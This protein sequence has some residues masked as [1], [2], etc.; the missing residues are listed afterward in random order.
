MGETESVAYEVS[1]GESDGESDA[2]RGRRTGLV[3][4]ACAGSA[5]SARERAA[6]LGVV[7]PEGADDLRYDTTSGLG[8]R[9]ETT[10]AAFQRFLDANHLPE[11]EPNT[12]AGEHAPVLCDV[13]PELSDAFVSRGTTSAAGVPL[14]ACVMDGFATQSVDVIV[15]AG[16]SSG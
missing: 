2:G 6:E 11:P 13:G 16:A 12:V 1:D 15:V 8:L 10:G 9:F 5:V 7:L 14:A 3:G 4:T